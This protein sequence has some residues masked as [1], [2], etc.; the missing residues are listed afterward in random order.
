MNAHKRRILRRIQA[1][2]GDRC[3]RTDPQ[4]GDTYTFAINRA[5]VD[6]VEERAVRSVRTVRRRDGVFV[7]EDWSSLSDWGRGV[8][9]N[10]ARGSYDSGS[11]KRAT[12]TRALELLS[13]I[14]DV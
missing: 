5:Y 1:R 11:G 13:G 10:Y 9:S 12:T 14:G 8:L 3:P 4:P 7:C 2:Q 6:T